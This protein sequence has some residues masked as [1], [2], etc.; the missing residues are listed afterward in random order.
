MP[1]AW[2]PAG[3]PP[4]GGILP[5]GPRLLPQSS[6]R[7][8]PPHSPQPH[9]STCSAAPGRK[10]SSESPPALHGRSSPY[11]TA[12]PHRAQTYPPPCTADRPLPLCR[13]RMPLHPLCFRATYTSQKQIKNDCLSP[14]CCNPLPAHDGVCAVRF[15]PALR[16]TPGP[17][18][19]HAVRSLSALLPGKLA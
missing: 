8:T 10:R 7:H 11:R 5:G 17:A 2:R 14:L 18:P 12:A 4:A 6:L 9:F 15:P 16:D 13:Q 3:K 1:P 19:V